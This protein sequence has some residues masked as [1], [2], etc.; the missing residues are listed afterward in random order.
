MDDAPVAMAPVAMTATS[1]DPDASAG[2]APTA[3]RPDAAAM[4]TPETAAD[5]DKVRARRFAQQVDRSVRNVRFDAAAWVA[6]RDGDTLP[7]RYES[8][9]A[10]LLP[11]PPVVA[12]APFEDADALAFVRAT[13][14]DPAYQLK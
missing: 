2:M 9:R 13:L 8:A 10:L 3:A 14:L 4:A 5:E 6:R 12:D 1:T 7:A 11:L